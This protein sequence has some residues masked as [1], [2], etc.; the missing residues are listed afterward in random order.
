MT[1]QLDV[2]RGRNIVAR[3]HAIAEQRLEHLT[4]LFESGRWRRFHSEASFIE[5]IEEAKA[6]VETWR[7]LMTR[8]ASKDNSPIDIAWLGI[9]RT[10]PSLAD[11]NRERPPAKPLQ[12]SLAPLFSANHVV[13]SVSETAV[14][15][16]GKAG[17]DGPL[18]ERISQ[19]ARDI[20]AIGNRYPLLHNAL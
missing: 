13:A 11:R 7:D 14:P 8:E 5:N 16:A 4:E 2:A 10:T 15:L 20:T 6:A 19:L 1:H 9:P 17:L 18:S 12:P 3:W